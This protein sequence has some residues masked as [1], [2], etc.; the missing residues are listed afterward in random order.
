M[1]N[2]MNNF[3]YE[4][5][6]GKRFVGMENGVYLN[7]SDLRDYS[8]SYDTLNGRIARFY[9]PT[10]ARK[11]PLVIIGKTGDEATEVKNR[12]FEIAEA[13]IVA[14]IPGKIYSGEYYTQ[15]YITASSKSKYLANKRFCKIDLTLTS[16]DPVWYREK[17]Y[18]F[19]PTPST[20]VGEGF[21][22][23]FG[24][25]YDY[26]TKTKTAQNIECNSINGNEFRLT[27]YGS[28]KNPSIKIGV[29]EYSITG[30]IGAGETLLVD[31]VA[32][33]I[34]LTSQIG[35]EHNWFDRR[36]RDSYIFEP[37]PSGYHTVSWDGSFGFDL[38]VIEKRS[39]PR[40]I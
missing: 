10:K 12:L 22:Y 27:V 6:L 40:W 24:Y 38:T 19:M 14:M 15:G 3:V 32:K 23:P 35:Q 37:I 39:E 31:S 36:N 34:T 28:V 7:T 9:R 8:W 18:R 26:S 29:H 30:E 2:E 17:L 21:D 20:D 16:A 25:P 5:H 11:L 1:L 33:K 4:N 13:D